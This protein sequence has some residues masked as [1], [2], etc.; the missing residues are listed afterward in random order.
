MAFLQGFSIRTVT[1]EKILEVPGGRGIEIFREMGPDREMCSELPTE[2]GQV[3]IMRSV[4]CVLERVIL[5]PVLRKSFLS[6]FLS[7]ER[8]ILKPWM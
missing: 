5:W 1:L 4:H 6:Q 2:A 7:G 3:V 8:I